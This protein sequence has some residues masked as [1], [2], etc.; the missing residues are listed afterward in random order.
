MVMMPVVVTVPII[1]GEQQPPPPLIFSLKKRG[2]HRKWQCSNKN[3]PTTMMMN[4]HDDE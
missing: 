4:E 3:E 2:P 1:S